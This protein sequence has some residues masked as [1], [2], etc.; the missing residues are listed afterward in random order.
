MHLCM[1]E[2][3]CLSHPW[4]LISCSPHNVRSTQGTHLVREKPW[5]RI[6]SKLVIDIQIVITSAGFGPR[7]VCSKA[8]AKGRKKNKNNNSK[9]TKQ[10]GKQMLELSVGSVGGDRCE[11]QA[12]ASAYL[13][14]KHLD[15]FLCSGVK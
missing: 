7:C 8:R 13:L 11:G 3:V 15:I 1:C 10:N 6:V 14:Q 4:N 5:L 2:R 9:I 12:K